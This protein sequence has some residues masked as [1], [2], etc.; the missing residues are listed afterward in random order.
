MTNSGIAKK[1][2][3]EN[4]IFLYTAKAFVEPF[5][6]HLSRNIIGREVFLFYTLLLPIANKKVLVS[7]GSRTVPLWETTRQG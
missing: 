3:S 4:T 7:Q 1:K 2:S 5:V 6:L